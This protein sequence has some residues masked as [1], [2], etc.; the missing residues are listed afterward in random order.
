MKILFLGPAHPEFLEFLS[1]LGDEV[2]VTNEPLTADSEQLKQLD[3][4]ISYGYR[5]ILKKDILDMFPKKSVNLHIS[6]LPWNRGADPNLWS[7]LED[8]PKGVTIHYIDYG[9]DTG[10][11]LAQR[12]VRFKNGQTLKTSYE[13][14]SRVMLELFKTVWPDIRQGKLQAMQQPSG[15]T[16]HRVGDKAKYEALLSQGW[17][18]P[19]SGLIGKARKSPK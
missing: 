3:F 13:E 4:I 14:L 16:F 9:V 11:V 2:C 17:D 15:G 12:E 1:S 10:D 7:F 18:T 5:H 6:L 19:V 8:T